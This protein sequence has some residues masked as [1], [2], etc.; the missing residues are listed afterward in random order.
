MRNQAAFNRT[1]LI[2]PN[3]LVTKIATHAPHQLELLFDS[4]ASDGHLHDAA[5]IDLV[6]SNKGMVVH[7][8]EEAHDELAIHAIRHTAMSRNG[9]AKVLDLESA[10]E[11][12]SE[13]T[14]KRCNERG[15]GGQYQSVQLHRGHSEGEG[16]VHV[17]WQE[18]QRRQ[19]VRL[20][21]EDGIPSTL[22]TS[23][24]VRAE[25]LN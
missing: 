10:L 18:E 12:R 2:S 3:T 5:E 24:D 23:K 7:V 9:V 15:K 25:I 17:G 16:L 22:K 6:K 1:Y 14:A 19:A 21:D 11:P 20:G 8:G 13:E 4:Q